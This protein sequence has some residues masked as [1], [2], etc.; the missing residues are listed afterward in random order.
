MNSRGRRSLKIK[1]SRVV[2]ARSELTPQW[3]TPTIVSPRELK[4]VI[5]RERFGS[6]LILI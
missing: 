3:K 1:E 2:L 4:V 6:L 5:V